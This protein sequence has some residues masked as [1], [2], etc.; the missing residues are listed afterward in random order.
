MAGQVIMQGFIGW[1][2][3]LWL[4]RLVTMVPAFVV[5]GAGY[6]ATRSLIISQVILS[7]VL[8]VPMVALVLL[9]RRRDIMGPMAQ[10]PLMLVLASAATLAIIALNAALLADMAGA[11]PGIA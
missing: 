7:L 1:R 4:R 8:P 3:P 9:S 11:L 6:D 2:I 10:G 5:V